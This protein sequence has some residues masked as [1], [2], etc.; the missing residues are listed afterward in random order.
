MYVYKVNR[1]N[2]NLKCSVGFEQNNVI[3]MTFA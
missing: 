3:Q 2:E 1:F